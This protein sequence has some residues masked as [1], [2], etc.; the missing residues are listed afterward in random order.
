MRFT[1]T[2]SSVCVTNN[3]PHPVDVQKRAF[4]K[5]FRKFLQSSESLITA[6]A[7]H[8]D[9]LVKPN[10]PKMY[11]RCQYFHSITQLFLL[12]CLNLICQQQITSFSH[13]PSWRNAT[14]AELCWGK[15]KGS[16]SGINTFRNWLA[17]LETS[18]Q[19]IFKRGAIKESIWITLWFQSSLLQTSCPWPW[20]W[21]LTKADKRFSEKT[22]DVFGNRELVSFFFTRS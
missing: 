14:H 15:L 1:G 11:L 22:E 7:Q 9:Y 3:A 12:N 19:F 21:R 2:V 20:T 5:F 8:H 6:M 4:S 16:K 18:W 17:H 10:W 13:S